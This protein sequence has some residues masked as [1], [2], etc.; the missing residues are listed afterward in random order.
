MDT[1][2]D[3]IKE[4]YNR[5][6]DKLVCDLEITCF[7]IIQLTDKSN[8]IQ[9]NEFLLEKNKYFKFISFLYTNIKSN[10]TNNSYYNDLYNTI[11]YILKFNSLYPEYKIYY[12]KNIMLKQLIEKSKL[13]SGIYKKY[14]G[15]V[16]FIVVILTAALILLRTSDITG[17]SNGLTTNLINQALNTEF[18]NAIKDSTI[19]DDRHCVVNSI[20]QTTPAKLLKPN[21]TLSDKILYTYKREWDFAIQNHDSIKTKNKDLGTF[22]PLQRTIVYTSSGCGDHCY[23]LER[24]TIIYNATEAVRAHLKEM[25]LGYFD[26]IGNIIGS[27]IYNNE[28]AFNAFINVKNNKLM[29]L[30]KD[31]LY[32]GKP[33]MVYEEG[34]FTPE[35]EPLLKHRSYKIKQYI[36][37]DPNNEKDNI[38]KFQING[39]NK[40]DM[41]KSLKISMESITEDNYHG[42]N[43]YD[44]SSEIIDTIDHLYKSISDTVD[45]KYSEYMEIGKNEPRIEKISKI[46]PILT[47]DVGFYNFNDD[48]DIYIL[49]IYSEYINKIQIM[50]ADIFMM[51]AMDYNM[52][53]VL[54]EQLL[55]FIIL[56]KKITD[57]LKELDN[58]ILVVET[59][60]SSLDNTVEKSLEIKIIFKDTIRDT[61]QVFLEFSKDELFLAIL[62]LTYEKSLLLIAQIIDKYSYNYEYIATDIIEPLYYPFL[63]KVDN[64]VGG[65]ITKLKNM[66][67]KYLKYKTKYLKYKNI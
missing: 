1:F 27:T 59:R 58:N 55:Y 66:K 57:I 37:P 35:E 9:E 26:N 15:G 65:Y 25:A 62:K 5:V 44:T 67:Q 14:E 23:T 51:C 30:D 52:R 31:N 39:P 34:F 61:Q 24:Q 10:D 29:I 50:F 4:L 41:L 42:H 43:T 45:E 56:E 20:I 16:G 38:F 17:F 32:S 33:Y 54:Q 22:G 19:N 49:V 7:T 53:E 12:K 64:N 18:N 47:Y 60:K 48:N 28:H 40:N 36:S 6:F 21:S 63:N 8:I 46:Y 13:N 2:D 11:I 3:N